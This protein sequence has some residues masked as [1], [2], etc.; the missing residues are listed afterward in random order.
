MQDHTDNWNQLLVSVQV[1][2]LDGREMIRPISDSTAD[3]F[4]HVEHPPVLMDRHPLNRLQTPDQEA[5]H[6]REA[7]GLREQ[8][9][10]PSKILL[11]CFDTTIIVREVPETDILLDIKKH[12]AP[13]GQGSEVGL[14]PTIGV[15]ALE[16]QRQNNIPV[17]RRARR[18]N[19]R[20]FVPKDVP[21][22]VG[23]EG[24]EVKIGKVESKPYSAPIV[25]VARV[26][27]QDQVEVPLC[28]AH[29]NAC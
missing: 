23:L 14:E 5:S 13:K 28:W 18:Y 24:L 4:P 10:N 16:R 20:V 2:A 25:G 19:D 29:V 17:G 12:A 1:S 26:R 27:V 6:N 15:A 7:H 22:T 8:D 21:H 3:L 9:T 11:E